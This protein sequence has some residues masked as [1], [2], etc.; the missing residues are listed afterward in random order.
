MSSFSITF[1][2]VPANS[3]IKSI[4]KMDRGAIFDVNT[5]ENWFMARTSLSVKE[6]ETIPNVRKVMKTKSEGLMALMV[7]GAVEKINGLDNL[8]EEQVKKQI[9]EG[10]GLRAQILI[11]MWD[12]HKDMLPMTEQNNSDG[13]GDEED[14]EK[15]KNDKEMNKKKKKKKNGDEEEDDEEEEDEE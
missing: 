9:K 15:D 14:D 11:G 6:L 8:T 2:G 4:H 13:E 10:M 12:E 5:G 1:S 7:L 3:V